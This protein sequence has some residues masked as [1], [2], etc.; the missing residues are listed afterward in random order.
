MSMVNKSW[1][2]YQDQLKGAI[3]SVGTVV[4]E[5]NECPLAE[6]TSVVVGLHL[7]NRVAIPIPLPV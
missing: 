5:D 6:V 7:G 2:T 3:S 4:R 1:K